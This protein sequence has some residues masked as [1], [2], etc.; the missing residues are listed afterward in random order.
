MQPKL[1]FLAGSEPVKKTENQFWKWFI[2]CFSQVFGENKIYFNFFDRSVQHKIIQQF[3]TTNF[4]L[5][6]W[7]WIFRPEIQ[8]YLSEKKNTI[9]SKVY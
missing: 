4:F 2:R 3:G 9:V 6:N 8:S 7:N 5:F 1:S